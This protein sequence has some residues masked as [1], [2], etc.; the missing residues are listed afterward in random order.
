MRIKSFPHPLNDRKP[1]IVT[2][3]PSN[4]K[5]RDQKYKKE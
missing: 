5:K 3:R 1:G 4:E 2:K